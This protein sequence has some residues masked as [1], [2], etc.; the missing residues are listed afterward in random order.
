MYSINDA[1]VPRHN[2]LEDNRKANKDSTKL[3]KSAIN[4]SHN[5]GGTDPQFY[6]LEQIQ[7]TGYEKL[8]F[9][10]RK[11]DVA[12]RSSVAVDEPF[13]SAPRRHTSKVLNKADRVQSI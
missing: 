4:T 1:L 3:F 11:S 9:F 12:N 2:L 6:D 13:K 10:R 5:S 8:S 7:D